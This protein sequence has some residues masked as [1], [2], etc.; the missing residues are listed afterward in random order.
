MLHRPPPRRSTRKVTVERSLTLN[1]TRSRARPPAAT[2][3]RESDTRESLG[4]RA[5]E[6][7]DQL[8][9][10]GLTGLDIEHH[11]VVPVAGEALVGHDQPGSEEAG[12]RGSVEGHG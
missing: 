4:A 12:A 8:G 2:R 11:L 7:G 3:L 10:S 6:A 1:L 9:Q 5:I